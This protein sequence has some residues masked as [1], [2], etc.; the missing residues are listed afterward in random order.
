MKTRT[1]G[2]TEWQ[3]SEIGLSTWQLGA[4][5][6]DVS[7]ASAEIILSQAVESGVNFFDTADVYGLG[8]SENR[9]AQF[10]KQ[11]SEKIYV[12]TKLGRHPEPGWPENFSLESFRTHRKLSAPFEC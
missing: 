12:A 11:R 8:I 4:D 10:L 3:V 9:I 2:K 6:G 5:W 1:F 7:D